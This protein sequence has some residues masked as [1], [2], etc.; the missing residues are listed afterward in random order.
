MRIISYNK[1]KS[2]IMRTDYRILMVTVLISSLFA[3][4]YC[5]QTQVWSVDDCIQYA[6]EK[7]IQVQKAK[8]SN[9]IN[10][11]NLKYAKSA[12]YPS[13]SG[14]A[15]QNFDWSNQVNTQQDQLY[16]KEVKVQTCLLNSG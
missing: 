8:V 16:L 11:I 2:E 4:W 3:A 13:L 12:W 7:N 14:T 6:L 10:G 9:D 1:L 5:A 15:R